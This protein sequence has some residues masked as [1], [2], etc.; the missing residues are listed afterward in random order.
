MYQFIK[1][2]KVS[3]SFS[4]FL[5]IHF[6]LSFS[7][8][9]CYLRRRKLFVLSESPKITRNVRLCFSLCTKFSRRIDQ[10]WI[11]PRKSWRLLC[12]FSNRI[13]PANR[14]RSIGI[15]LQSLTL[16]SLYC[17]LFS[18]TAFTGTSSLSTIFLFFLVKLF[19][20]ASFVLFDCVT[21]AILGF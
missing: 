18:F 17:L 14:R 10:R 4:L 21:V 8:S 12:R 5:R 9:L 20:L 7:L 15:Q 13:L 3:L 6:T 2:N 16:S 11:W 1:P 19:S